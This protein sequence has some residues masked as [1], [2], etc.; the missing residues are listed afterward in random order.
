MAPKINLK[1]PPADSIKSSGPISI[2]RIMI[3]SKATTA[4]IMS[5]SSQVTITSLVDLT[6]AFVDGELRSSFL[7][8]RYSFN[9]TQVNLFAVY[10]ILGNKMMAGR[11]TLF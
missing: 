5:C 4:I 7:E 6:D 3:T 10:P 2:M 8:L 1:H 11:N 9:L